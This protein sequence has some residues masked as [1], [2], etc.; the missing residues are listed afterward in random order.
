[1]RSR[2]SP[3]CA[4]RRQQ[5]Q[6]RRAHTHTQKKNGRKKV[7]AAANAFRCRSHAGKVKFFHFAVAKCMHAPLHMLVF[8]RASEYLTH[9]LIDAVDAITGSLRFLCV[10]WWCCCFRA[11]HRLSSSLGRAWPLASVHGYPGEG[12]GGR[13]ARLSRALAPAHRD[14]PRSLFFHRHQQPPRFGR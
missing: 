5:R 11:N 8:Q 10:C 7:F 9:Q 3:K 4:R 2:T 1:M 6:R 13:S 12:G 14:R